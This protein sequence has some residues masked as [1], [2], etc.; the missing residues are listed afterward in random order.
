MSAIV[1]VPERYGLPAVPSH[2]VACS[3][4]TG[5]TWLSNRAVLGPEDV[6]LCVICAM[7]VVKPGDTIEPAPWVVVDLAERLEGE[8]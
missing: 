8:G 6:I 1:T 4:C 3:R 2:R 7:A 5:A